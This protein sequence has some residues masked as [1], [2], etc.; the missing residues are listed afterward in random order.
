MS[1]TEGKAA[2]GGGAAM[3]E[4]LLGMQAYGFVSGA[5]TAGH[6]QP[7]FTL[8]DYHGWGRVHRTAEQ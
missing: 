8:E 3:S 4:E 6:K 1:R 5:A 7:R 2:G